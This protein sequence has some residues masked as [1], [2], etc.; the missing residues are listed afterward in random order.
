MD[1]ELGPVDRITADAVG[2]PGERTFFLQARRG[3]RLV[4]VL[5]E[6]QQV[7]L[8]AASVV[9]ILARIGKDTGEGAPEEEMGLENP[10]LP[11]WRVGR[12]SIGYEEDRDLLLL[13]AEELVP[14]ADDEDDEE[15]EEEE[16]ATA[17]LDP[18]TAQEDLLPSDDD[19]DSASEEATEPSRVRIWATREQMLAMARHGAA[20]ASRG[21][22][23][24]RF[25]DQPMDPEGHVCPAMNGHRRADTE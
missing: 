21:R 12:L 9:E 23:L 4:T 7:Q 22:P 20:V 1:I 13:E 6:K 15:S 18:L 19:G 17:P 3:D 25:C 16:L 24:C 11:E 2:Q 8:L 14:D 10:L 5:I